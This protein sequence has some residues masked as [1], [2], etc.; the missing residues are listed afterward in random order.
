MEF[1][2]A[3]GAFLFAGART[4]QT[5]VQGIQAAVFL[6]KPAEQFLTRRCACA[7]RVTVVV[8]S[9]SHASAFADE[10]FSAIET[11]INTK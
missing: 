9:V 2:H 8:V 4:L 1:K 11:G 7:E 6:R 3:R 5:S 10:T